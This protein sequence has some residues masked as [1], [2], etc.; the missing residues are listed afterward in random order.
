VTK[1]DVLQWLK[2]SRVVPVV[3]A[4]SADQALRLVDL[5][6]AGGI[7]VFEVTMTVPGAVGVIND[8]RRAFASEVLL[9][10]GTVMDLETAKAC[11]D[12]GAQFIVAPNT[13]DALVEWLVGG[14]IFVAPGA[15]TP[16]EVVH[17]HSLGAD[18]VKVFPC[19]AVG[20]A[21]YIK[22]LKAP[23][24]HIELMPT[25]GVTAENAADYIRAGAC[26]VGAGGN[27]VDAKLLHTDPAQ[28]TKLASQYC[29]SARA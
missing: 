17:T 8:L 1:T 15:L 16:T 27:L 18:V 5:L 6:H 11:L 3:R 28:I 23:L 25:G 29:T 19:S 9:G 20:G 22:A 26:C 2:R 24:P 12:A 21:S 13:D 4:D 14:Q 7:D 10:A